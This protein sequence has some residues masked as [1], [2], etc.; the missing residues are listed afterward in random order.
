MKSKT[1]ILPMNKEPKT[2]FWQKSSDFFFEPFT[3]DTLEETQEKMEV[4]CSKRKAAIDYIVSEGKSKI[5]SMYMA[6]VVG[7]IVMGLATVSLGFVFWPTD[8]VFIH[9]GKWY[10]CLLQCGIIWMGKGCSSELEVFHV[11]D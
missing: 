7:G 10:Q 11:E 3:A 4:A 2:S 8:N 5:S 6:W 1:R 9:P